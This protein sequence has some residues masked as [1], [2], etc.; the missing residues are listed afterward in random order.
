MG[1]T[2]APTTPIQPLPT[3][4]AM[5]K[6]AAAIAC[7]TA[8][9]EFGNSTGNGND[10][11]QNTPALTTTWQEKCRYIC[12]DANV[13]SRG[14]CYVICSFL[15]VDDVNGIGRDFI[16]PTPATSTPMP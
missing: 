11:T 6:Y 3:T 7:A 8:Q 13:M 1:P 9:G 10:Q 15:L 12:K 2:P 16:T 14:S 5:F 4:P